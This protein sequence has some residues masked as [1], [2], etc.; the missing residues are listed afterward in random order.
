MKVEKYSRCHF[1]E[2]K[3]HTIGRKKYANELKSKMS[4]EVVK[5]NEKKSEDWR[6][7][8]NPRA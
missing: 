5:N 1:S 3:L 2:P 8:P 6:L 4:R 7:C